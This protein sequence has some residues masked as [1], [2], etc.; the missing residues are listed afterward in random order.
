M[1]SESAALANHNG[2]MVEEIVQTL[3]PELQYVGKNLDAVYHE[4]PLEIK[5]CQRTCHRSDRGRGERSGRFWFRAD[6]DKVLKEEDGFYALVVHDKG[7]LC[8]FYLTEAR[9]LLK[10][11]SGA[12]TVSWRTIARRVL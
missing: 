7:N 10:D 6:Q 5:S 11:F 12:M 3:L 4:R 2:K 9:L 8:F 1:T